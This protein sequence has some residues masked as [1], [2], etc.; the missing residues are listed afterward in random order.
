MSSE[1]AALCKTDKGVKNIAETLNAGKGDAAQTMLNDCLHARV[2][3]DPESHKAW[4]EFV[5]ATTPDEKLKAADRDMAAEA[6][7]Q[8]NLW[9]SVVKAQGTDSD[10][11]LCKLELTMDGK[12]AT[13]AEI[14]KSA[15]CQKTQYEY[16]LGE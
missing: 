11:Q 13:M 9:Q 15:T 2:N 5:K 4:T 10:K 12:T 1:S 14:K 8:T 6:K 3:A 16:K 7:V